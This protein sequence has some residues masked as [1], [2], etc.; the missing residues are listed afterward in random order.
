MS[1]RFH[2]TGCGTPWIVAP[3]YRYQSNPN[4]KLETAEPFDIRKG[5]IRGFLAVCLLVLAAWFAISAFS[6]APREASAATPAASNNT[7][8]GIEAA[9]GSNRGRRFGISRRYI[10]YIKSGQRWKYLEGGLHA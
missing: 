3:G 6:Q 10:G 4:A 9:G 1:R 7:P 5:T 2:T 8:A